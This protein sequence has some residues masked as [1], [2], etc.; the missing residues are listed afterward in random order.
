VFSADL[1]YVAVRT[2][3]LEPVPVPESFRLAAG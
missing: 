2:G 3:T 1:V